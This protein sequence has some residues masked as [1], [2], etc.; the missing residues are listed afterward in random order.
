[1]MEELKAQSGALYY[2][3]FLRKKGVL[4]DD[5]AKK[6]YLDSMVWALNHISRGMYTG[7]GKRKPYS[8]LA[9]IQVGF[10]M[11]QGALTWDPNATAANGKD[12]G[13]YRIDFAKFPAAVDKLMVT[14]GG[15]KAKADRPGA[16]AFS[17]KYVD[18]TVVPQKTI[19]D[20]SLKFPQPNF[21]YSI[22]R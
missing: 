14:V 15:F 9:A 18:G 10:L 22:D 8:Q 17:K 12:Q 6:G 5:E 13:A 21:V 7:A 11:D 1:M 16:E 2:V 19:A 20:R 3:E 4:S